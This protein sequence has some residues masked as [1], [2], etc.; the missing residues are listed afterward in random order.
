VLY[1]YVPSQLIERPKAGFSIPLGDWLRGPLREWAEV[2]LDEH[3]LK[4]EGFFNVQFVRAQ[5][6][7]HLEGRRNNQSFLWNILMFQVWLEEN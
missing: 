5:W 6:Q 7:S 2:L 1:Q 3:R 4:Q